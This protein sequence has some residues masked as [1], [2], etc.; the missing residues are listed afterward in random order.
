MAIIDNFLTESGLLV[1]RGE[2][3]SYGFP[4]G[5]EY[6]TRELLKLKSES[7]K[8]DNSQEKTV[9]CE[10]I[11]GA[12]VS[13]DVG[14]MYNNAPIVEAEQLKMPGYFYRIITEA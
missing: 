10:Y 6:K 3:D 4:N 11:I 2:L 5:T 7:F 8:A 1:K 14:D 12:N 13:V 9:K